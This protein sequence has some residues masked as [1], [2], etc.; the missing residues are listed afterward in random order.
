MRLVPE[1]ALA[2]LP[3]AHS[4]R[5]RPDR[6]YPY[7]T[8]NG[9]ITHFVMR[10]ERKAHRGFVH[11]PCC[12]A[13]PAEGGTPAWRWMQ[14]ERKNRPLFGLERLTPMWLHQHSE[15]RAD[16]HHV[17]LVESEAEA[18]AWQAVFDKAETGDIALAW[19]G[20]GLGHGNADLSPLAGLSVK[21][22]ACRAR[23]FK[24]GL[25][26]LVGESQ[27]AKAGEALALRFAGMAGS[28][29]EVVR[30]ASL[31]ERV[32]AGFLTSDSGGAKAGL[33]DLLADGVGLD[34]VFEYYQS[35]GS[36]GMAV[37]HYL[38]RS[39]AALAKKTPAALRDEGLGA[40]AAPAAEAYV[41]YLD[42]RAAGYAD[43]RWLERVLRDDRARPRDCRDNL[44][45]ILMYH[46]DWHGVISAD[47]FSRKLI[48]VKSNPLGI[49]V[50]AEWSGEHDVAFGLWL[51]RCKELQLSIKSPGTIREAV[52]FAAIKNPKNDLVDW[53]RSLKGKWDGVPR[54]GGW[55]Q[56]CLGCDDT[57]Y[58]RLV[59]RYWLT[60]MV[61]RAL[62]PGCISDYMPILEGAQGLGKS[63]FLAVLGG[64][65][66]SD[67]P[68]VIGQKDA[69]LALQGHWLMEI[70]ELNSMSKAD[71][72]AMKN[73]ITSR[74]DTFRAPYDARPSS[75]G[76]TVMFVGTTNEDFYLHDPT[77]NRRYWPLTVRCTDRAA[78]AG[79]REQLFAEAYEAYCARE[80]CW[81]T[82]QEEH[83]Y[84]KTEQEDREAGDPWVSIAETWIDKQEVERPRE[85]YTTTQLLLNM[86]PADTRPQLDK[87]SSMRAADCLKKLG[88]TERVRAM[89]GGAREWR[90]SRPKAVVDSETAKAV[91]DA[92]GGAHVPF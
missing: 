14:Y 91:S 74:V 7:K 61:H 53:L 38:A 67:T 82:R 57:E 70:A 78:L 50:G 87:R 63:K 9:E 44:I 17:A 85:W 20:G 86:F 19:S 36:V 71:D 84:F 65:F 10:F 72:K 40:V 90:Y 34:R 80:R 22:Y 42:A 18:A 16:G 92:I 83:L 26:G 21:Y 37:E 23:D 62:E 39:S 12:W 48:C 29:F 47:T 79:M 68:I 35:T 49:A 54:L 69:Y 5:G 2:S 1:A 58:V 75:H 4:V 11:L 27:A 55:L 25:Y 59:G 43:A 41:G 46:P 3:R 64:D 31:P 81:P 76:R 51:K 32:E 28:A 15:S 73:F 77:G 33:V 8:R 89:T 6:V 45:E 13:W 66:F 56:E 60:A 88:F 24:D 30:L 52:N